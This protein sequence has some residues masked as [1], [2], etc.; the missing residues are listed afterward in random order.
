MRY[1]PGQNPDAPY[2]PSQGTKVVS[3]LL[4]G[5]GFP[6]VC[7]NSPGKKMSVYLVDMHRSSGWKTRSWLS[8]FLHE[9]Q[10]RREIM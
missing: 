1:H 5:T 6:F 8:I 7:S 4:M 2:L 10:W 3:I 9:N